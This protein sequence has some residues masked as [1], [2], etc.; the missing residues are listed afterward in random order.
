MWELGAPPF[1]QTPP[2]H[3]GHQ[4]ISYIRTD[5]LVPLESPECGFSMVLTFKKKKTPQPFDDSQSR[6]SGTCFVSPQVC[7]NEMALNVPT[8]VG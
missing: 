8:R 3:Y 7:P 5:M 4:N 2:S 1:P 6:S